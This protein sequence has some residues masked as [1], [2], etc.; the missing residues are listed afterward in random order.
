MWVLSFVA[1]VIG[2]FS[3][4]SAFAS[5]AALAIENLVDELLFSPHFGERWGRHWLDVARYSDSNGMDEDIAHPNAHRYRD[6]VIA[7]FNDDKP[8]DQFI[9]E[10]LA[11]DLLPANDL[12]K[13]RAQTIGTR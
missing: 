13:R 1:F 8:F 7:A 2:I 3:W 6:Y 10:Q 9:V 11:G 5:D 4:R 12:D